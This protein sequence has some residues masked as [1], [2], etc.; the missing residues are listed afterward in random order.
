MQAK[1]NDET[2]ARQAPL[3]PFFQDQIDQLGLGLGLKI[4]SGL[5]LGLGLALGSGLR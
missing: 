5:G 1:D 3:R 4:G 2:S